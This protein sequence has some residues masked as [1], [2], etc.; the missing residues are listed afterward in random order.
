MLLPGELFQVIVE[1]R[2]AG[3]PEAPE[4][5]GPFGDVLQR[6]GRQRARPRLGVTATLNEPGA[7]EHAQVLRDGR[8]AH[9]KGLRQLFHGG[10]AAGQSR[11]DG[12]SGRIGESEKGGAE[13][14]GGGAHG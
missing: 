10:G 12:A 11:E 3:I 7:L 8:T 14:V 4:L 13:R 2:V 6:R 9:F 5:A 1:A